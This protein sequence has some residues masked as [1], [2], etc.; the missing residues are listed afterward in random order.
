MLT[1]FANEK[2]RRSVMCVDPTHTFLYP[3]SSFRFHQKLSSALPR[4]AA[5][6]AHPPRVSFQPRGAATRR[7]SVARGRPLERQSGGGLPG[8]MRRGGSI[9][10]DVMVLLA[11][12]TE[13]PASTRGVAATLE[14]VTFGRRGRRPC[15]VDNMYPEWHSQ[16]LLLGVRLT[17]QHR[18]HHL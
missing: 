17:E 2:Q 5:A 7:G 16:N 13:Q 11:R 15:I 10:V 14:L 1:P 6:R 3:P 18:A 9:P 8:E 4:G 12:L